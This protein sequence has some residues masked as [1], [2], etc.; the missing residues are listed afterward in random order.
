M[1]R[2][3]SLACSTP[4]CPNRWVT[5]FGRRLCG[6]CAAKFSGGGANAPAPRQASIAG[7]PTLR[8][9]VRPFT[10]P[11]ERDEQPEF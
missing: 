8:D 6:E 7:M 2:E 9:A 11:V 5:N 10:E 1:T 3:R 4:S